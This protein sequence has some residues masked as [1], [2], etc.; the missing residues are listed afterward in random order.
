M[1]QALMA[2]LAPVAG[3]RRYW[4]KRPQGDSGYPY[5]I[6]QKISAPIDYHMQGP[7]NLRQSRVQVDIYSNDWRTLYTASRDLIALVSGYRDER[8]RGI[9]V[10]NQ[11]DLPASD[12]GE[13]EHLFRTSIDLMVNYKEN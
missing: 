9:F 1:E 7:D 8:F 5:L 3:G 10:D 6:L 11:R 12:A 4:L 2:L 13:V